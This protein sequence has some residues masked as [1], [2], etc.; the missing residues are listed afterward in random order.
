MGPVAG[1]DYNSPYLIANSVISFPPL[2]QW[3][4]WSG[5]DLSYICLLIPKQQIG[6]GGGGGR[7]ES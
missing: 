7:D 2:L 6:K 5:E 4:R 3:E 1:V